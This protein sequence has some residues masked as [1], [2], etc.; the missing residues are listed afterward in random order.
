MKKCLALLL[1]MM[2]CFALVSCGGEV[3]DMVVDGENT[4]VSDF[5]ITTLREYMESD[6]YLA[7]KQ[8][9]EDSFGYAAR[10]L[11]VTKVIE[12]VA[13]NLGENQISVHFLAIKA[14][15]DYGTENGFFA[16]ILLVVDYETGEVYDEFTLDRDWFSMNGT[17]EQQIA[18]ML[19][20]PLVGDGYNG[21]TII[22][23]SEK[24]TTL[25]KKD[26]AAINEAIAC[27]DESTDLNGQSKSLKTE[28]Y[29]EGAVKVYSFTADKMGNGSVDCVLEYT[30]P[31]RRHIAI[32]NPP[33][34]DLF[35]YMPENKTTGEKSTL[36]FT[37]E[38]EHVKLIEEITVN[39]YAT[40]NENDFIVLKFFDVSDDEDN[41]EIKEEINEEETYTMYKGK[42]CLSE[43]QMMRCAKVIELTA[44]N[45]RD[46]FT[47]ETNTDN[48]GEYATI[49][50]NTGDSFAYVWYNDTNHR[51]N[52]ITFRN[53]NSGKTES[54]HFGMADSTRKY[55][56]NFD[57]LDFVESTGKLVLFDVP[58]TCWSIDVDG[59]PYIY[60]GSV[61][62]S[63]AV[64]T[65]RGCRIN[66]NDMADHIDMMDML[67]KYFPQ[68]EIIDVPKE[69]EETTSTSD[70][71]EEPKETTIPLTLENWQEY[72]ELGA[73]VSGVNYNGFGEFESLR[74]NFSFF[75]KAD[76]ADKVTKIENLVFE[77]ALRDGYFTWYEYNLETGELLQKQAASAD[78]VPSYHQVSDYQGVRTPATNVKAYGAFVRTMMFKLSESVSGDRYT[79]IGDAFRTME[80]TRIQGTITIAE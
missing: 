50:L 53:R 58:E 69:T 40:G 39:F 65:F 61:T 35:M 36:T 75:L 71:Q 30:A 44:E 55:Y 54:V 41:T 10:D 3:T 22:V 42:I 37:I 59:T 48:K 7:R 8:I 28:Y 70:V 13:D 73:Y 6:G 32:F 38:S 26:I 51:Y 63:G 45:W 77:V 15:C 31:A 66:Q 80:I 47:I 12:I 9:F 23:K 19:N 27:V 5:L 56:L 4:A 29:E 64:T 33:N 67:K 24:R 20:G 18:Y 68:D 17:K 14:D 2:L 46:Y 11:T 49:L 74:T 72:F 57:E 1:A 76:I 79:F 78:E 62:Q 34:G 60:F 25:S 43:E 16:N 52:D 21:G